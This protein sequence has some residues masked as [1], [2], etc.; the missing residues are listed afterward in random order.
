M[1]AA[2]RSRAYIGSPMA[3]SSTPLLLVRALKPNGF[4]E[5]FSRWRDSAPASDHRLPAETIGRDLEFENMAGAEGFEPSALGFG[6]RCSD[7]A[8]LRPYRPKPRL[9]SSDGCL[10]RQRRCEI[11]T[12]SALPA[13]RRQQLRSAADTR[14]GSVGAADAAAGRHF[15]A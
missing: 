5:D 12:F 4:T 3:T 14:A 6:D 15:G 13:L 10:P 7:Q 1:G 2:T 8:E 9:A 11:S